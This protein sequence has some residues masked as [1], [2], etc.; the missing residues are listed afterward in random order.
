[1]LSTE[2]ERRDFC[3][4]SSLSFFLDCQRMTVSSKRADRIVRIVPVG[5]DGE[6]R[7]VPRFVPDSRCLRWQIVS[8]RV[9]SADRCVWNVNHAAW[10]SPGSRRQCEIQLRCEIYSSSQPSLERR[11]LGESW[12][13]NITI[14]IVFRYLN[15]GLF[16]YFTHHPSSILNYY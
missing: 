3:D 6:K 9:P 16:Y 5:V 10:S 1:M 2:I 7:D 4:T 8:M 15:A 11:Y 12:Q 13:A 14:A